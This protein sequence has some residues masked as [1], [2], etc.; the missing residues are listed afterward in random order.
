MLPGLDKGMTGSSNRRILGLDAHV[1]PYR[2]IGD[3]CEV[4]RAEV[5]DSIIVDNTVIN[6]ERKI[7]RN[8]IGKGSKILSAKG[9]LPKGERLV[10]GE[11]TTLLL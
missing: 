11:N 3:G 4:A 6:V 7:V 1:R 9:L 5:D 2:A 10:V 8:M